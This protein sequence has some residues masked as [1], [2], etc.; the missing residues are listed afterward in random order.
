MCVLR[1]LFNL[2]S[3]QGNSLHTQFQ[4]SRLACVVAVSFS[5]IFKILSLFLFSVDFEPYS[6]IDERSFGDSFEVWVHI[7][8][9][10]LA[11]HVRCLVPFNFE[12]QQV[13]RFYFMSD[14]GYTKTHP[15]CSVSKQV[16]YFQFIYFSHDAR[17]LF[18]DDFRKRV[19]L[20]G[21]HEISAFEVAYFIVIGRSESEGKFVSI[22]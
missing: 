17:L 3:D 18:R 16:L 6:Y 22:A 15:R 11:L 20:H 5:S 9:L 14:M 12:E 19:Y 1:Q 10:L 8:S 21:V 4:K 7:H 2:W 13:R